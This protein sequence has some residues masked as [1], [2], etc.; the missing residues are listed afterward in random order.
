MKRSRTSRLV[1]L[2]L[3]TVAMAVLSWCIAAPAAAQS[4]GPD[5]SSPN[6]QSE[7]LYVIDYTSEESVRQYINDLPHFHIMGNPDRPPRITTG[8]CYRQEL[9]RG[10]TPSSIRFVALVYSTLTGTRLAVC[11][12]DAPI[13]KVTARSMCQHLGLA[14][15]KTEGAVITCIKK[16]A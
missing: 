11:A 4:D 8:T 6:F 12:S 13:M 3:S 14:E 5:P 10:A 16:S 7:G 9:R 15:H 2:S 1:Q